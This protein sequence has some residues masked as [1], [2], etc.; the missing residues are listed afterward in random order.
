MDLGTLQEKIYRTT[1]RK[2]S[3]DET[4]VLDA[5]E[6]ACRRYHRRRFRFN[7]TTA[8]IALNGER[9]ERSPDGNLDDG[10]DPATYYYPWDLL[11]SI[12]LSRLEWTPSIHLVEYTL[13]ELTKQFSV[14]STGIPQGYAWDDDELVV[15]PVVSA[16]YEIELSYLKDVN[17]PVLQWSEGIWTVI[18]SV[19]G[20]KME[21]TQTSPWFDEAQDLIH[22]SACNELFMGVYGDMEKAGRAAQMEMRALRDLQRFDSMFQEP[23]SAKAHY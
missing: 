19:S 2:S 10:G 16:G 5:I 1:S 22:W 18:D 23:R 8:T 13:T 21:K 15:R 14:N 7:V 4:H 3:T 11:R 17:R 6:K 20:A 9:T 12:R